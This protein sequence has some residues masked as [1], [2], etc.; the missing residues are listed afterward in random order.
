MPNLILNQDLTPLPTSQEGTPSLAPNHVGALNLDTLTDTPYIGNA[1]EWLKLDLADLPGSV[2]TTDETPTEILDIETEANTT[3]FID[4]VISCNN[5]DN[6]KVYTSKW[7]VGYIST[8]ILGTP[9]KDEYKLNPLDTMSAAFSIDAG[10][11][12]LDVT[13]MAA[14]TF[15]WK[16]SYKLYSFAY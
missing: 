11:L 9:E 1:T 12:K 5:S 4:I 7:R 15:H 14:E 2:T 10:H 13:G 3:Y 6:S 16:I 8:A